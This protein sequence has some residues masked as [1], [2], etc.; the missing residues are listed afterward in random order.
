MTIRNMDREEIAVIH[1]L[2][3][4]D[5]PFWTDKMQEQMVSILAEAK[6]RGKI[7]V[8]TDPQKIST[9]LLSL[10]D[11]VLLD[12]DFGNAMYSGMNLAKKI[13]TIRPDAVILFVTNFIEYAPDGYE[14]QAFRYILKPKLEDDLKNAVLMAVQQM[15]K[16]RQTFQFVSDGEPIIL[17]IED[18]LYFEVQQHTV[19]V[20]FIREKVSQVLHTIQFH[21]SLSEVES[22]LVSL[23]F[24]RV[25]NNYLVNMQH[26]VRFQCHEITLDHQIKLNVSEKN[27]ARNKEQYL[28]W[29]GK[30][31]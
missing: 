3:C 24:L 8:F 9:H 31:F 23:G 26:I 30:N 18:I 20:H 13:R 29:K 22:N 19:T 14:V 4:D 6:I 25:H 5:E 21:A 11:I 28:L 1:I 7:H 15:R 16:K 27:Y 17:L 2:I 12:I 10:C